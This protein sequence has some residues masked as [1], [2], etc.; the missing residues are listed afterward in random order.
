MEPKT[1]YVLFSRLS[2]ALGSDLS[3]ILLVRRLMAI[4]EWLVMCHSIFWFAYPP[5]GIPRVG[6]KVTVKAL[7]L[8]LY[9]QV[10]A[11]G[12]GQ[13][14]VVNYPRSG[15]ISRSENPTLKAFF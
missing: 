7:L 4:R 15:E 10:N 9:D 8:G 1:F 3:H 13:I 12:S 6:P 14:L 11:L 2:Q 5:P